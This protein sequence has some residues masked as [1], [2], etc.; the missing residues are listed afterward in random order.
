VTHDLVIVGLGPA[1]ASAVLWARTFGL[2]ALA[3]DAGAEVGGQLLRV[4]FHPR[5]VVGVTSGDGRALA[6]SMAQQL[7]AEHASIRLGVVATALEP[8]PDGVTVRDASGAPHAART[9]LIA[10]G[11]SRRRLG[12]PGETE[13]EGR[14]V[15]YSATRD[16][17]QLAGRDVLV[18]GGGDAAFENALNLAS[19]GSRVTLAVRGA[20]RARAEFRARVAATP[21]I[22]L[23][24][25][26]EVR[27]VEGDGRVRGARLE[28][29]DGVETL[30]VEGVVIK[31]GNVPNTTWCRGQVDCDAEGFVRADPVGRTSSP[32]VWAA[33]DVTRPRPFAV[34]VAAGQAARAV[35]ALRDWLRRP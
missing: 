23:R 9:A 30:A 10:T 7:E 2:D 26:T 6:A 25:R 3:L 13:F 15:T 1:G 34:S 19:A 4:H 28:G 17:A 32:R 33:G 8:S 14:G 11:L 35:A 22:A 24:E 29:P 27:A 16:H 12:V 5:E 18:V 20:V 21:A 31:V